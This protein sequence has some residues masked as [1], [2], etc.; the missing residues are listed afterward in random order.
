MNINC[1]IRSSLSRL[2]LTLCLTWYMP[3]IT[4]SLWFYRGYVSG[5]AHFHTSDSEYKLLNTFKFIKAVSNTV[6][7]MIYAVYHDKLLVFIG[8]TFR[9]K[10]VSHHQTTNINCWIRLS[11]SRLFLTLYLTWYMSFI[12]KRLWFSAI[13]TSIYLFLLQIVRIGMFEVHCDEL[14]Q[15]LCKRAK[16]LRGR[17]LQRMLKDHQSYNNRFVWKIVYLWYC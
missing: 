14:I 6:F 5:E 10:L 3:F 16:N 9:E 13:V 4:T 17:L 7:D 2:F 1:W 8:A 11:L 15:G 12:M